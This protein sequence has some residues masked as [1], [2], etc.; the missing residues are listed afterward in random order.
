MTTKHTDG[1]IGQ[2]EKRERLSFSSAQNTP[3]HNKSS[4]KTPK[5]ASTARHGTLAFNGFANIFD[6]RDELLLGMNV[7]LLVDIAH[8]NFDRTFGYKQPLRYSVPIPPSNDMLDYIQ[9]TLRKTTTDA[10]GLA[11]LVERKTRRFLDIIDS[12]H[13][14]V[15]THIA[16]IHE[17]Q[18][19]YEREYQDQ[20]KENR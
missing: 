18:R 5:H 15:S 19:D 10:E 11:A 6:K 9:F 8:M 13:S 20:H 2:T 4:E 16:F 1:F 12:N 3:W 17:I 14:P 7:E